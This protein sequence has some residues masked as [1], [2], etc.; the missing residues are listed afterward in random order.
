MANGNGLPKPE[1]VWVALSLIV[2]AV[3]AAL[4]AQ[5]RSRFIDTLD[6][7]AKD[8]EA[9]RQVVAINV[10]NGRRRALTQSVQVAARF[11]ERIVVEL[12]AARR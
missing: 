7:L 9:R 5:Q 8:Q 1:P 12:R 10:T 4:S 11:I 2:W 6:S 3:A